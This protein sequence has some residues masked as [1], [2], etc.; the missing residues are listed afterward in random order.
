MGQSCVKVEAEDEKTQIP[1]LSDDERLPSG[2]LFSA[3]SST[4][5]S[6]KCEQQQQQQNASK[7]DASEQ[8]L[9]QQQQ[10]VEEWNLKIGVDCAPQEATTTTPTAA[11][12]QRQQRPSALALGSSGEEE[13]HLPLP[14][15][16]M[17]D[18]IAGSAT[19]RNQNVDGRALPQRT[20]SFR[21]NNSSCNNKGKKAV[22]SDL[23]IMQFPNMLVTSIEPSEHSRTWNPAL[24]PP[25]GSSSTNPTNAVVNPSMLN[26]LS[27]QSFS[28]ITAVGGGVNSEVGGGGGTTANNT[29]SHS[30]SLMPLSQTC[31]PH[32][33][34]T[35]TKSE[36][37]AVMLGGQQ[38]TQ[39]RDTHFVAARGTMSSEVGPGP[40][41]S[42]LAGLEEVDDLFVRSDNPDDNEDGADEAH[43]R[44]ANPHQK[45]PK[46]P[47]RRTSNATDAEHHQPS[48]LKTKK[49][50]V[51]K[52]GKRPSLTSP[53]QQALLDSSNN[54]NNN[55][56]NNNIGTAGA[57]TMV[58]DQERAF[59]SP[60]TD[61]VGALPPSSAAQPPAGLR[62]MDPTGFHS[63]MDE[64]CP[65]NKLQFAPL[66]ER[67]D[68]SPAP[69]SSCF[70][71]DPIFSPR[72]EPQHITSHLHLEDCRVDSGNVR[73][74]PKFAQPTAA[75]ATRDPPPPLKPLRTSRAAQQPSSAAAA[76]GDNPQDVG[77]T[78]DRE[79]NKRS[80]RCRKVV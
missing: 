36:E 47:K 31:A 78:P 8:S 41:G 70:L 66:E 46:H 61:P 44:D 39:S 34:A 58:I 37:G 53:S 71:Q 19:K 62:V 5:A 49:R 38:P 9:H 3:P 14:G 28:N 12:D 10:Q 27:V 17:T 59:R 33:M 51:K 1:S 73:P 48:P 43:G 42:T 74:L 29:A 52:G 6:P 77:T 26:P 55:N 63:V 13:D 50:V 76:N 25:S 60:L 79:T 57:T 18:L 11:Q 67:E 20:M 35:S 4:T 69:S 15:S 40:L 56:T 54:N 65:Q 32:S 7:P 68:H 16:S 45:Q 24:G 64:F 2:P 22:A 75:P 30:H 72:G 80:T 23:P 21:E